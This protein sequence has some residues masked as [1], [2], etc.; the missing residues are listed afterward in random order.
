MPIFETIRNADDLYGEYI[1]CQT[2]S[3]CKPYAKHL[4]AYVFSIFSLVVANLINIPSRT[5]GGKD[6]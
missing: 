4:S 5:I 3:L 1:W 6:F 2:S